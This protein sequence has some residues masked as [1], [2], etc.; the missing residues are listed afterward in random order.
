MK[1]RSWSATTGRPARDERRAMMRTR[2]VAIEMDIDAIELYH[3]GQRVSP[4]IYLSLEGS[5]EIQ[6]SQEDVLPA[7]H[8]GQVAIYRLRPENWSERQ[9][10]IE[11]R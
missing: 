3:A 1:A 9:A 7:T 10:R 5:R 6:L 4:G 11:R 8:D 2:E